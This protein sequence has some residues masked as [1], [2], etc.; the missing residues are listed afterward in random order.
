MFLWSF[1]WFNFFVEILPIT[2]HVIPQK[3]R[4]ALSLTFIKIVKVKAQIKS[5]HDHFF[6]VFILLTVCDACHP[7]FVSILLYLKLFPKSVHC[8]FLI[9]EFFNF[10]F[11]MTIIQSIL[12]RRMQK[13]N[14]RIFLLHVYWLVIHGF[15]SFHLV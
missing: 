9:L 2:I 5:F 6:F 12:T 7:R 4:F 11:L 1:G 10:L 3:N 14:Q 13:S 8:V 15:R